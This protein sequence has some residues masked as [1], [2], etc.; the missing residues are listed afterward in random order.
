[1]FK[2]MGQIPSYAA[3]EALRAASERALSC[4]MTDGS[5]K[6]WL[7]EASTG[8]VIGGAGVHIKPQL[9]R[10][11]G[12]KV[13]SDAVPLVVNVYVEPAWRR[14]GIASALMRKLMQWAVEKGV[15]RVL[16]HASAEGRPLYD[17]LG[18]TQTN[19]MRWTP[20]G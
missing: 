13:A 4:L 14:R 6:G 19:E 1:M 7:A 11:A 8:A 20:P 9:P 17:L 15:D 18:F 12:N 3:G 5:Y 2:D 16:L 10:M